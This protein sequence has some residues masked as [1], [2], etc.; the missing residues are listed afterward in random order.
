VAA[1]AKPTLTAPAAL[2]VVCRDGSRMAALSRAMAFFAPEIE[3]IEFPAWDCL[4]YDRVSPHSGLVAERMAALFQL[5]RGKRP[6]RPGRPAVV[7]TT[8][9]AALQRVPARSLVAGQALS[10]APGNLLRMDDVVRWLDLNGFLR[11]STVREP[12]D[13]AVRGGIVDL[14]A[15]GMELPVRLDF[16]GDTLESIRSFDPQTQRTAG[17][18]RALDLVPVAEF[19]LTAETIARFRRGH[20]AAFGA[21]RPDDLLY[22][23]VSEGRRHPGM[24]HWLP[25]FHDRLETLFDYLPGAPVVL[26][27]LAEDA[28]S[29]R[30]AQISD[31]YDARRQP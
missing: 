4:P 23:A 22:E 31:Y 10:A 29:E 25:L 7:L 3:L 19:Q 16:F 15:P 14:F 1:R 13:Y 21:A 28:A 5:A 12:G 11:A 24:E 17:Q 30:L 18:L 6:D 9:N 20:L 27:P 2:L 8:V 26:E